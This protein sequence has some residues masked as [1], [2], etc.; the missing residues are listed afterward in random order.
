M[1]TRQ[2]VPN[3]FI[4]TTSKS[5]LLKNKDAVSLGAGLRKF[6]LLAPKF[7]NKKKQVFKA[8]AREKCLL[9]YFKKAKTEDNQVKTN[10]AHFE[11]L[12]NFVAKILI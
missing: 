2:V 7:S 4:T 11:S 9:Q 1:D 6:W 3:C 12:Q 10:S 8:F 5:H